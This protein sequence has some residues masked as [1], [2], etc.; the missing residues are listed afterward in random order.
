MPDHTA[1]TDPVILM[2]RIWKHTKARPVVYTG[3]FVK[4]PFLMKLIGAL[5]MDSTSDGSGSW[6]LWKIRKQ[7]KAV[8]HTLAEEGE[9]V[10]IY[11]SGQLRSDEFESLGGKSSA[12]E[13][14]SENTGTPVV[15]V[16]IRG[17]RGSFLSRFYTGGVRTPDGLHLKALLKANWMRWL[18]NRVPVTI[19]FERFDTLPKFASV[20]EC[21]RWLERWYHQ[22]PD[23]VPEGR[24]QWQVQ[25]FDYG[26]KAADHDNVAID[27]RIAAKVI[28][29]IAKEQGGRAQEISLDD[30]LISDLGLDSL[31]TISLYMWVEEEFGHSVDMNAPLVT[32]R[33]VALAAQGVLTEVVVE[34][35]EET[36]AHWIEENRKAPASIPG[37]HNIPY[38]FLRTMRRLG[39]SAI[40]MGDERIGGKCTLTYGQVC[41]RGLMLSQIV[42]SLPGKRVGI[43]LPASAGAAVTGLSVMFAGRVPVFLN[44][45]NGSAALDESI[46]IAGVGVVLTSDAFL[47][48]AQCML[49]DET[50]AKLLPLEQVR[51]QLGLKHLI[52]GKLLSRLPTWML[53]R[54]L[55]ANFKRDEDA[56]I[57]FTSGSEK[58]PKGVRLTHRNILSN[59]HGALTAI[60]GEPT[61]VMLGFLPPF[62]SFGLTLINML[63]LTGGVKTAYEPDPKKYRRLAK[64]TRKW[65]ATLIPG[66]PDFLSGILTSGSIE[67]FKTVRAFL[68]GAQKAPASLRA[69]VERVNSVL[70]E[71]YGITETGPLISVNRIGHPMVGVGQP[72]LDSEVIF[73]NPATHEI[74]A[75]ENEGLILV[76]G[77][78]VSPG[79]L[80]EMPFPILHAY[81]ADW[82]NTGDLGKKMPEGDIVITGRQ[83]LFLKS[84]GEM[85]SIP[86]IEETL[87]GLWPTGENGPVVT[88]HGEERDGQPALV[89]LYTT[90]ESAT[91]EKANAALKSAGLSPLSYV[92][93]RCVLP[94]IPLLG[95]GKTNRRALPKPTDVLATQAQSAAA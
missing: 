35:V 66:T 49:S 71:G 2:S 23:P 17:L 72:I 5:P 28:A 74:V 3:Q 52:R 69:L 22:T 6:K 61:D 47:D 92:R 80:G 60:G 46:R 44:W 30:E 45:T 16:R 51:K 9:N 58:A 75:D 14:I 4:H 13:L 32:V 67:D 43:M 90:D 8:H 20:D 79:Y 85:V 54:V 24:E 38:A 86:A 88:V 15:L 41:E 19:E 29:F 40:A 93:V 73:V 18:F 95:T 39:R 76:Q 62:H 11:P 77:P 56:V 59:V 34:Q 42:R 53:L 7:K 68:S 83:S 37:A 65:Q 27:S 87:I 33:D 82:Y 1:L 89:C 48:K 94:E 55:G 50:A 57:L 63:C 81:G 84:G 25:G 10:L 36:P 12:F 91:L 31:T 70:I 78:G 64:Q 26:R 21:N